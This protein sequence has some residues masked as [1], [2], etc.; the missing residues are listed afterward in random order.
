MV[1]L[2]FY[3]SL[4]ILHSLLMGLVVSDFVPVCRIFAFLSSHYTFSSRARVFKRQSRRLGESRIYHLPPLSL[5]LECVVL[6]PVHTIDAYKAKKRRGNRH[7]ARKRKISFFLLLH[8]RP[9]LCFH[10]ASA[11]LHGVN[12]ALV[13]TEIVY[14]SSCV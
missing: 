7:N 13:C 11:S 4:A 2:K 8:L 5:C 3:P 10:S 14:V 6:M 1:L 12:K 9:F